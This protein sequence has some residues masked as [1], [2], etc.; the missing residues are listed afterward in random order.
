MEADTPNYWQDKITRW[1]KN[2]AI[3]VKTLGEKYYLEHL[4]R[5]KENLKNAKV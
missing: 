5:F 1:K 4:A 2:K 3:I